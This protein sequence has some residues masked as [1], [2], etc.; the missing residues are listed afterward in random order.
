VC[1]LTFSR[2]SWF[3]CVRTGNPVD[4]DGKH[5]LALVLGA[6]LS[7]SGA[8]TTY[9]YLAGLIRYIDAL[10]GAHTTDAG[11]LWFP[12]SSDEAS[13][14]AAVNSAYVLAAYAD[15]SPPSDSS[16]RVVKARTLAAK[17]L[18]YVLG[19]NPAG[20]TYITGATPSS[21]RNPQSAMATAAG[22]DED[23][24]D[25]EPK[26]E[27]HTLFGAL[28]GGPDEEDGFEDKR[29]NYRQSEVALDYNALLTP[30]YVSAMA[31]GKCQA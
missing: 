29:S 30:L 7:L 9:D 3:Q 12:G 21:P 31:A 18:D 20:R 22:P 2:R 28:V 4:W 17:Q 23:D 19:D 13:L 8:N 16:E 6:Q 24:I 10:L 25:S 15:L 14:V 11:L 26:E 1:K 27:R 5:G